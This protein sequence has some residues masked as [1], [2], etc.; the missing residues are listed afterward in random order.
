[1]TGTDSSPASSAQPVVEIVPARGAP[2]AWV[3]ALAYT[4]LVVYAS[5][6]PF[7]DWRQPSAEILHFLSAPWPRYITLDD[8]LINVAAYVPLGFLL[9]VALASRVKASWS[10]LAAALLALLLSLTMET[11]QAFLATRIA[12]KVD[13]LTNS[14]GG[15]FGAMAAPLFSPSGFPGRRIVAWRARV[16]GEG[17]IA[18]IGLV[19]ACL[20]LATHLHPTAQLFGAGNLRN[21]FDLPARL[22]HNPL[23]LFSAEAAIVFFNVIG[24]GLLVATLVRDSRR[25]LPLVFGVL[26][27]GLVLKPLAGVALFDV[28]HPF[29]W[30][31]PGVGLGLTAGAILLLPLVRAPR[32]LGLT[33]ALACL[34][35]AVV[36]INLAPENPY[37]TIPPKLLTAGAT[38]LL[39]L[40]NMVRALSELW[41]FLAVGYLFT[42]LVAREPR[43]RSA[44]PPENPL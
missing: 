29:N 27:A 26:G 41:P 25:T 38:Q 5:L 13:V 3:L 30:L 18:D 31:T 2:L 44:P 14:V 33:V 7:R 9:A 11:A 36:A 24:V 10:V 17:T 35:A 43:H 4:L 16:L 19:V 15:L 23:L 20:W 42:A 12:S 21:T 8:V 22:P 39:R 1:M 6:Q 32:L 28:A 40:S 34:A 37:Y